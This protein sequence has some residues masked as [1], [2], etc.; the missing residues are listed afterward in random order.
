MRLKKSSSGTVGP[1]ADDGGAHLW[2]SSLEPWHFI[3][4]SKKSSSSSMLLLAIKWPSTDG[5]VRWLRRRPGR[6]LKLARWSSRR[7]LCELAS[8]SRNSSVWGETTEAEKDFCILCGGVEDVATE[9][10]ENLFFSWKWHLWSSILLLW[11]RLSRSKNPSSATVSR[12][13]LWRG[14]KS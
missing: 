4:I 11:N 7:R 10:A 6:L 5:L 12:L 1:F 3:N 9:A 14:E 13:F 8:K 2:S